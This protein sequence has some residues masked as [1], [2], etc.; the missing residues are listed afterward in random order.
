MGNASVETTLDAESTALDAD[1]LQAIVSLNKS[2]A[3]FYRKLS[4][5]YLHELTQEE[6]ERIAATDFTGLDGGDEDIAEGYREMKA[7]LQTL[8]TGT[9][10][11]LAC[12]YA[13][14]FLAAGN[15][16]TFAATPYESVFTSEEGLMMQDARDETYK[17]YCDEHMQP[18][19]SL[20]IPEDHLS[21]QFQFIALLLDRLNEAIDKHDWQQASTYANRIEKFHTEHQLNWVGD[22][23]DTVEDVAQTTFYTGIS[24]VTRGFVKSETD[25]IRDEAELFA[26]LASQQQV[27]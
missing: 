24:K 6:I 21:F 27:A 3:M 23:C 26:D 13:H 22:F 15:Y 11:Q 12:D 25:V 10:Q 2:R 16:E 17:M 9:R 8:T 5:Y 14:T 7:Y 20:R 19:E 4:Y 18:N 1:Q